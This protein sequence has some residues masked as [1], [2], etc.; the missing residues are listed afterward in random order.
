MKIVKL[1]SIITFTLFTIVSYS[2]SVKTQ[3]IIDTSLKNDAIK[4]Q[5]DVLV[6][7]SPTFQRFNNIK[8]VS[9][10]K[11]K[12]N[13]ADT[14][15]LYDKKYEVSNTKISEQAKEINTLKSKIEMIN[16]NLTSVTSEKDS[17]NLFGIQTTKTAYNTTLFSIILGLLVTT[18]LFLFKFRSSNIQTKKS[19]NLYEEV[20]SEFETH[21]KNSL[22]REQVLRRKLQDEINKQRNA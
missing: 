20:S 9:M 13:L 8:M 1:L 14:L 16:G 2:Q 12:A 18:L 5:L 22:E 7:K 10:K 11:F 6:E 15:A 3:K 19:K 17:I 21:K 4:T